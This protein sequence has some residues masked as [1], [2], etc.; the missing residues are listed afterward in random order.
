MRLYESASPALLRFF[1]KRVLDPEA[2]ADLTAETLAQAFESRASYD[3]ERGEP[4]ARL[5][6]IARRRLGRYFETLRLERSARERIGLVTPP[7]SEAD[8]ER[9]EELID[10]E[11]LGRRLAPA[12]QELSASQ[13]E[14][15]V[16]RFVDGLSY[17]EVAQRMGC[18]EEAVRTRVSR[19]LRA[20]AD[21]LA[22]TSNPYPDTEGC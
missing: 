22:A 15:V 7:L 3:P 16:L 11:Q 4:S 1:A 14:A 5:Y 18:S 21:T 9:I 2:A 12:L 20:L 13:R 10:F 8:Y 17:A 6:G 19:G